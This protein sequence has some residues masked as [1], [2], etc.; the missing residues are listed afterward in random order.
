MTFPFLKRESPSVSRVE[1]PSLDLD[2]KLFAT[3]GVKF[4]A[5]AFEQLFE[6]ADVVRDV[7]LSPFATRRSSRWF[8]A[9]VET[10]QYRAF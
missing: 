5:D 6:F 2:I 9:V 7:T 8:Q 10:S 4:E 3:E 1:H